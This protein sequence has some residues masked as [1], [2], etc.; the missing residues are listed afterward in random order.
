MGPNLELADVLRFGVFE[1][2]RRSGELYRSGRKVRL[3]EQPFEVLLTLLDHPGG[4][5]SQEELREKLWPG[6]TFLDF[7]HAT[8]AAINKIRDALGDDAH[9]PRFVETL[10]RRGYRFIAP[11]ERG[12]PQP[13]PRQPDPQPAES[14][15]GKGRLGRRIIGFCTLV[16]AAA[17]LAGARKRRR[18]IRS[19]AV[20]RFKNLSPDSEQE[21]IANALTQALTTALGRVAGL[22]V[23]SRTSSDRYGSGRTAPE[24]ARE[25]NVQTIVEGSV[26]LSGGRVRITVAL[27]D[28]ADRFLW[29]DTYECAFGDILALQSA[30]SEVAVRAIKL[31]L[32]LR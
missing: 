9:S 32:S 2:D 30:F 21:Y 23:I 15:D 13:E 27:V 31:R 19:V 14:P 25:L 8:R 12:R 5:V 11:V 17:A 22:R 29:S 28:A 3:Q 20:L 1:V 26:L 6:A 24:I 10:P 16:V 18:A 4:V 7:D